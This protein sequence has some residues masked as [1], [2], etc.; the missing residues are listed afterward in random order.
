MPPSGRSASPSATTPRAHAIQSLLVLYSRRYEDALACYRE[1]L[2]LWPDRPGPVWGTISVLILQNRWREA[3]AAVRRAT[4]QPPLPDDVPVSREL[5]Q[6]EYVR[7]EPFLQNAIRRGV[8]NSY[9]LA[10]YYA[11]RG[12]TDRAFAGLRLAIDQKVPSISWMLIDPRLDGLRTDARYDALTHYGRL[13][14]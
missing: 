7:F 10:V 9:A 5:F 12:D 4:Q 2:A 8:L 1:M 14:R 3:I 6:H 13:V 11:E